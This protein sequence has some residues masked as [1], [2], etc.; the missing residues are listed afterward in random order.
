M[1]YALTDIVEDILGHP[2][3]ERGENA[4]VR[5]PLHEDRRPSLSVNLENGLW[6]CFSCGEKGGLAKLARICE[7]P[8]DHD[9]L[10]LRSVHSDV[11]VE[12]PPDFAML[13]HELHARA[14]REQPRP[15]VDYINAKGLHS[16]VFK[17]YRLGWDGVK[18]AMPYYD[19]GR[20]VAIKYRY[21]DGHKDAEKGSRRAIYGIDDVRGKPI[22]IICEG[23][24]DTHAVWSE[25][26]RR[27]ADEEV[28]VCGIPGA[29]VAKAQWELWSLD[30]MWARRIYLLFDND[31]A[32]E[33][34]AS[35]ALNVF[36][37]E[38]IVRV[39]PVLGKDIND[40]LLKGG[41]L[42]QAGLAASDL[43][44]QVSS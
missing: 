44:T 9:E 2:V 31:E 40:H 35:I 4:M 37:A 5:C 1:R 22:V 14:L 3:P 19:D 21:P 24:S 26:R 23:E 33:R 42:E 16:G 8:L 41:T 13:A 28:A 12:E 20:V 32:G 36:E 25:L 29:Q 6:L 39:R 27:R 38:R 18:L 15:L 43:L 34:G 10:A 11:V 7:S 17:H 30:L